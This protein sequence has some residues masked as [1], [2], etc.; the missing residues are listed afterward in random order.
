[1]GEGSATRHLPT[2]PF[3]GPGSNPLGSLS[4]MFKHLIQGVLEPFFVCAVPVRGA[5]ERADLC[6][7]A[8][9]DTTLTCAQELWVLWDERMRMPIQLAE[10]IALSRAAELSLGHRV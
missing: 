9:F 4:L 2:G 1:M 7:K 5:D 8:L 3:P 10:M 6:G